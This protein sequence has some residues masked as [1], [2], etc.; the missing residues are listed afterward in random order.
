MCFFGTPHTRMKL[1]FLMG[2]KYFF[3]QVTCRWTTFEI[4]GDIDV[5]DRGPSNSMSSRSIQSGWLTSLLM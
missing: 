3:T 5:V 2:L 1:H 4:A